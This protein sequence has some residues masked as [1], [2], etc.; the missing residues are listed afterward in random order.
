MNK[1]KDYQKANLHSNSAQ[2]KSTEMKNY[3]TT[4][5]EEPNTLFDKKFKNAPKFT[6]VEMYSLINM[7]YCTILL[8]DML[9]NWKKYNKDGR[10]DWTLFSQLDI[11]C[12]TIGAFL[13]LLGWMF[14]IGFLLCRSS[15]RENYEL[16]NFETLEKLKFY[17]K[18]GLNLY[19]VTK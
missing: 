19:Q 11:A 5:V 18:I 7:F 14:S 2:I 9:Q 6:F 15:I 13:A 10:N 16:E 4:G 8:L 12:Y 17:C 1:D 3:Q